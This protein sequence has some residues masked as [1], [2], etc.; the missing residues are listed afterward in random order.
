MWWQTLP[1][2]TLTS[3]PPAALNNDLLVYHKDFPGTITTHSESPLLATANLS[4]PE[5]QHF[6]SPNS[7]HNT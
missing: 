1:Q 2:L 4:E 3:F 5:V 7:L 6:S